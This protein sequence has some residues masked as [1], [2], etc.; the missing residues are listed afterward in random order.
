MKNNSKEYQEIRIEYLQIK[1]T[2]EDKKNL[3][4]L[5]EKNECSMANYLIR[6]LRKEVEIEL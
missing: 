4:R 3:K 1:M 6:L 2:I 5:A